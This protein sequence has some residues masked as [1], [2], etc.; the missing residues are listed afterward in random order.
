MA[1]TPATALRSELPRKLG[2]L[3][4]LNIVVGTIIGSAIFVVPSTVAQNLSSPW[5][6]LAAWV[7]AGFLSLFGALGYAEL[8]AMI[9]A[10]G[11]QY[12]FLRE[13]W[14]PLWGFLCGWTFMLAARSG[15]IAAVAA[16][17]AIY[18]SHFVPLTPVVSRIVA[19]ALILSLTFVNYRGVR[20][21]A[22]VQNIF[23]AFKVLGLLVLIVSAL[24]SGWNFEG[25]RSAPGRDLSE[26]RFGLGII[27]C[28]WAY[29][30]WYAISFVAG[31]IKDPGRNLPRAIIFGTGLVIVIYVLANVAY[32]KTLTLPEIAAAD[33]VAAAAAARTMGAAGAIF[34]SLTILISTFGTTNGNMMTAPRLYCAQAR[35]GLFFR[36]FGRVHP[37]FETPYISIWGQ[38]IW[39]AVLA[40]SGSYVQLMAYATFTFWIFY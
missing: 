2:A 25:F 39:A 5:M 22:N 28:L 12:V 37:R 40:L 8:G 14:G 7:L 26:A 15:A 3:D 10:T 24:A 29:N 6:M 23:T 21:G 31:E 19:A 9:P 20:L 35:D 33:R 17:F 27:A 34:V 38:G 13:A 16:G 11:G 1:V 30:G 4:A 32:L 36:S 18:L